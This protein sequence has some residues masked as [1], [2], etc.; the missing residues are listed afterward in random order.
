MTSLYSLIKDMGLPDKYN[1]APAYTGEILPGENSRTIQYQ[2]GF[3]AALTD[4]YE[5]LKKISLE[6]VLKAKVTGEDNESRH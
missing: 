6:D 1:I 2:Y 4:V 3:N 5:A